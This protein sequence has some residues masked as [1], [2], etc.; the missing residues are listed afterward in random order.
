MA[1]VLTF[2][3]LTTA[4]QQ[5]TERDDVDFLS[6][7]PL[8]I[9]LGERRI[10]VDLS[11]LGFKVFITGNFI[12]GSSVLQKPTRWLNT[13]TFNVGSTPTS[14]VRNQ[15]LNRSYEYCRIYWPDPTLMGL[16]KYFSD[17]DQNHWLV[18]PTP[19]V[20]YPFEIGYFST[21]QFIDETT[22]TNFLTTTIPDLFIFA[23]LLETAPWLK[24]DDRIAIWETKYNTIRNNLDTEDKKRILD[25]FSQR[26]F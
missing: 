11:I 7:I 6:N 16:P 20:T 14:S 3:S 5:Y 22:S 26:G 13:S 9:M 2:D 24:D 23:C 19:D 18:V 21:P 17:Y 10:A 8:F 15:V 25:G 1:Y 4:I 12:G